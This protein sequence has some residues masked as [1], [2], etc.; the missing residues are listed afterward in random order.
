MVLMCRNLNMAAVEVMLIY[1]CQVFLQKF[2]YR[3]L[4]FVHVFFNRI[5]GF[6]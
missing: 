1:I 2:P 5:K 6:S 3:P 4:T